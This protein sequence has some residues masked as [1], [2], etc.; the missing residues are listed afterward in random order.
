MRVYWLKVQ[1]TVTARWRDLAVYEARDDASA[2]EHAIPLAQG[3]EFDLRDGY[4]R[5]ISTS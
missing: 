5:I 3:R 2:I 4:R 1:E